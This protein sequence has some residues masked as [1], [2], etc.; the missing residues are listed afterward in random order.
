MIIVEDGTIVENANSYVTVAELNAYATARGLTIESDEEPLLIRA[1]DYLESLHFIGLKLTEAQPLQWPRWNVFIDGFFVSSETIPSLLKE[2]Q[3][4]VALAID[5]GNDPLAD[6]PRVVSSVS[7]GAVSVSYMDGRALPLIRK[8][9][10]KLSKLIL[11]SG[12]TEFKVR[13]G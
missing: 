2:A 9:M 7:V 11:S 6:I 3:M 5:S 12:G 10:K 1:M 13:R 8:V 4:E